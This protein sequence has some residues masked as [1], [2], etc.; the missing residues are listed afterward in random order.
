[1][2]LTIREAEERVKESVRG[3]FC[4][5]SFQFLLTVLNH[6]IISYFFFS[7]SLYTDTTNRLTNPALPSRRIASVSPYR[8][9][10][11][12]DSDDHQWKQPNDKQGGSHF[13]RG[14]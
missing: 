7:L 11:N 3:T 4:N 9:A 2:F 8:S 5:L 14:S 12:G 13:G 6:R 10:W 1:M